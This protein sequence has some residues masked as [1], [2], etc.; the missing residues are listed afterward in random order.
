MLLAQAKTGTAQ[1]IEHV[2][3]EADK[4]DD[5]SLPS[6]NWRYITPRKTNALMS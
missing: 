3:S 4:P 6:T 5:I 1:S 2:Y